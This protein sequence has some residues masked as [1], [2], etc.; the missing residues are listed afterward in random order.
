MVF[1]LAWLFV[2][3]SEVKDYLAFLNAICTSC[4]GIEVK[5]H[6]TI[7]RPSL[8][9][10]YNDDLN[11]R[12][13]KK[14]VGKIATVERIGTA[15]TVVNLLK[16][17]TANNVSD[18]RKARLYHPPKA[19]KTWTKRVTYTEEYEERQNESI[20]Q[21]IVDNN[22]SNNNNNYDNVSNSDVNQMNIYMNNDNNYDENFME[23]NTTSNKIINNNQ[24]SI[25]PLQQ[26]MM[27]AIENLHWSHVSIQKELVE[28]KKMK[29]QNNYVNEMYKTMGIIEKKMSNEMIKISKQLG[30]ERRKWEEKQRSVL[31]DMKISN[32]ALLQELKRQSENNRLRK[33]SPYN[34][35][36]SNNKRYDTNNEY[37]YS[38]IK[39]V[40][41]PT[42]PAVNSNG[43][44]SPMSRWQQQEDNI[45]KINI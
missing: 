6:D 9:E 33:S 5:K 36:Y 31:T 7:K 24:V 32:E 26:H 21:A 17:D 42:L 43:S 22:N 2:G 45:K 27:T 37:P 3:D 11:R 16:G 19:R 1:E 29:H 10:R 15:G 25:N 28:L 12:T 39:K 44:T 35:D 30:H 40:V 13:E 20:Q 14:D 41:A 18:N 4:T 38:P 8:S 34:N 23:D